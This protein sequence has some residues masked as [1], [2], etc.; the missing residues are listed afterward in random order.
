MSN[1]GLLNDCNYSTQKKWSKNVKMIQK[2]C[3]W[4]EQLNGNGLKIIANDCKFQ[5]KTCEW[6]KKIEINQKTCEWSKN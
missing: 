4:S 1:H 3:E 2:M 5:D 6:S